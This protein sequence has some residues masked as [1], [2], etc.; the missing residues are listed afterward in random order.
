MTLKW[1][2]RRTEFSDLTA[3][4]HPNYDASFDQ[5]NQR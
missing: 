1:N 4:D 2:G 3:A 5:F